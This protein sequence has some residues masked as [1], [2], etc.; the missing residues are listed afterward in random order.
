MPPTKRDNIVFIDDSQMF[1]SMDSM[2]NEFAEWG[3]HFAPANVGFQFG[4]PG[5]KKWW[6][7]FENP[8]K[9]I[10]NEILNKIPNTKELYWVDFSLFDVYPPKTKENER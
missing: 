10:S 4:Y 5:D 3:A 9:E 8:M 2:I 7:E 1:V 6:S